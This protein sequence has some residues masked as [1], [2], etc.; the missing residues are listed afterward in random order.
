MD[1]T[2]GR[3]GDDAPAQVVED[4]V[5]VP[6]A[7]TTAW[8]AWADPQGIAGW[9]VDRAVG[10]VE[11]G[12][13]VVWAWERFGLEVEHEVVHAERPTRM[14]LRAAAP[15]AAGSVLEVTF[16]EAGGDTV[17]RIVQSGFGGEDA[18]GTRSGWALALGVLRHHLEA[19]Y[20]G[21]RRTEIIAL[22]EVPLPCAS[23]RPYL[24]TAEGL[25]RWLTTGPPALPP[26]SAGE[27]PWTLRG[28]F[29]R[30]GPLIADAGLESLHAWNELEGT[31]ELK[32][33]AT[34]AGSCMVGVR[35]MS[36]S[37][38]DRPFEAVEAELRSSVRRLAEH[39]LAGE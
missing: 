28:G 1:E 20:G 23:A 22:E 18:E 5:T 39:V 17:V 12:A 21:R 6:V 8:E 9:F 30:T 34:G 3:S 26:G 4:S 13:R 24:R 37:R 14:V 16:R 29:A 36:W 31:L 10:R 35:A 2:V 25:A 32:A 27:A 11:A 38:A 15:D 19:G 33:F 7:P